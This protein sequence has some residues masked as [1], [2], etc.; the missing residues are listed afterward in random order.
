MKVVIDTNVVVFANLSDEGLPAAIL[1]LAANKTILMF[2]S[3]PS[4]PNTKKCCAAPTS[5]FPLPPW[6][7]PWPSSATSA[8]WSSHPPLGRSSGRD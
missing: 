1:D 7:A 3:P 8:A 6:P 5:V 2:V 4:W